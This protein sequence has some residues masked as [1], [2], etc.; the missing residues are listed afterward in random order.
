M[1]TPV[2]LDVEMPAAQ[3]IEA[4]PAPVQSSISDDLFAA[5]RSMLDYIY[6]YRDDE[7]ES[8]V[9]GRI[10]CSDISTV[11]MTPLKSSTSSSISASS[12]ITTRSSK[13]LW[14]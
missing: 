14:L 8:E 5:M 9:V 12:P 2:D 4:D 1:S 6:D 10:D 13:N 11:A 3:S 7:Y